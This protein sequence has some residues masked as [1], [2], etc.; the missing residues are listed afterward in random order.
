MQTA[1]K[2]DTVLIS[3][4]VRTADGRVV[5]QTEENEPVAVTIG[6]GE[7][8]PDVE[9]ALDGLETGH[10]ASVVVS[11]DDAF[12]QHDA[13]MVVDI[14]RAQLPDD[15]SPQ[16]GMTLSA[17][18]PD[19]STINLTITE[20]GDDTVTADGNHPLAGEDLHFGLTLVDIK[21]AA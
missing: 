15:N 17:Q 19:G 14:P 13:G 10:E 18:Q 8:F 5:G 1:K 20:V 6:G 21:S 7:I 9:A 2:G 16:P 12:G 4:V 3:Y 11:A